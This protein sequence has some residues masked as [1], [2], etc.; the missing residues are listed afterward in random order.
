MSAGSVRNNF[1]LLRLFDLC[2]VLFV[3]IGLGLVVKPIETTAWQAVKEHQPELKLEG[4]EGALGQGLLVGVLG[5]FRTITADFFWIRAN[6]IWE[7][8]DRVKLDAMI[9]LVTTLDPRPDFFWINSARMIAYDVPNWR[10]RQEGGY[11][12]LPESRQ[13]EIDREQAEQ[14]FA[15]LEKARE[16][17]PD[18]AKLYLE[19]AQIYL[20]RLKDLENAARWFLLASQK[21]DAPYYAARIYAELLRREGR[22]KDAYSFLKQLYEE[23][24]DDPY[25]QKPT[26]LDRIREIETTLKVPVWQRFKLL[27]GVPNEESPEQKARVLEQTLGI[28]PVDLK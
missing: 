26:I 21:P 9:R 14:A 23:L 28:E 22:H 17:H 20:N 11:N 12:Q 3:L 25:A 2:C 16:F 4:I 27:E 10:I 15:L 13:Q 7:Q 6:A 18:K 24:P 8:Q 5:G 1:L 19:T